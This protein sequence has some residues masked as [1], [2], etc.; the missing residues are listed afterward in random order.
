M[1]VLAFEGRYIP[2][3]AAPPSGVR[4]RRYAFVNESDPESDPESE[5]FTYDLVNEEP[6]WEL[7]NEESAWELVLTAHPPDL[8]V[9]VAMFCANG[10]WLC[11]NLCDMH[12]FKPLGWHGDFTCRLTA[13]AIWDAVSSSYKGR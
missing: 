8:P 1:G 4:H 9:W 10:H 2:N 3:G 6:A 13:F 7:V 12:E 11:S 5:S